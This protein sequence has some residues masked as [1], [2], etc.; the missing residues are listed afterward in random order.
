MPAQHPGLCAEKSDTLGE[1]L[2]VPESTGSHDTV[3]TQVPTIQNEQAFV[4]TEHVLQSLE[5][6]YGEAAGKPVRPGRY[7]WQ[8]QRQGPREFTASFSQLARCALWRLFGS[9][10]IFSKL[11]SFKMSNNVYMEGKLLLFSR[12][13]LFSFFGSCTPRHLDKNCGPSPYICG[14]SAVPGPLRPIHG[15][16]SP[17]RC[18]YCP[19]PAVGRSSPETGRPAAESGVEPGLWP[20]RGAGNFYRGKKG[21][22]SSPHMGAEPLSRH[23]CLPSPPP[24]TP[25]LPSAWVACRHHSAP[26]SDEA[27]TPVPGDCWGRDHRGLDSSRG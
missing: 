4:N 23:H 3:K 18:L 6:M 22:A 14:S 27:G 1:N 5:R 25:H 10:E 26:M 24:P 15:A 9:F 17:G 2:D 12:Y 7:R 21:G 16:P 13:F 8:V 11:V 20:W 19:H